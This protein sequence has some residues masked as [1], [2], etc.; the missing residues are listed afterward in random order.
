M[1]DKRQDGPEEE[2]EGSAEEPTREEPDRRRRPPAPP[3]TNRPPRNRPPRRPQE[4]TGEAP[5]QPLRPEPRRLLRSRANR[6][7]GGVCGGLGRYFN[8][9]PD[10]VPHRGRRARAC[11]R[12]RRAALPRRPCCSC[13]AR[14]RRGRDSRPAEGRN[15]ALA[16][17]GVA[18]LLLVAWP[19]L[20]GGGLSCGNCPPARLSG[21]RRRTRLVARLRRGAERR[22][23]RRRAA[24]GARHRGPHPLRSHLPRR[25]LGGGGRRRT[26]WSRRSSSPRAPPSWPGAF[27][28]PVRW[29]ILPA[30]TL[31]LA[32]GAVA[33]AGI[34]L[35]G[36]VGEREYRPGVG[37]RPA[38]PLRARHR[39]ARGRPPRTPT[40]PQATCR[41]RSTSASA[42]RRVIVPEDVCV[43]TDADVGMG[44]V[45]V[46]DRDNGGIDVD[47]RGAPTPPRTRP[48]LCSTRTSALASST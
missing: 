39:R 8:V 44:D 18:L 48:A 25:R 15:R 17:A 16:I 46:F 42:R 47:S 38:R 20:L 7:I 14:A 5:T 32:A 26:A 11:R 33:A 6:V 13:R 9:D 2:R 37:G 10:P 31:A 27:L 4:P 30:V 3:P 28:K 36:G 1:D 35:D 24:R 22:R 45:R 21:R 19:F 29:L 43:A 23:G 34:D 41:S 12:R 40:C